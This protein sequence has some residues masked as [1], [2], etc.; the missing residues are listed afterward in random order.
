MTFFVINDIIYTIVKM[1]HCF[2]WRKDIT[3][4]QLQKA[5]QEIDLVDK[6]MARL[7]ERRMKAVAEVADHKKRNGLPIFDPDREEAVVRKNAE[8]LED[9]DLRPY[10][11]EFLRDTMKAS[12]HY[13]KKRMEGMQVAFCGIEGAFASIAAGK[14]FP[15]A[16]QVPFA[17]FHTAYEAVEK[18][19]CDVAVLPM[20]NSTAGEVSQVLD[21]MYAGSL[22]VTGV[23][24]LSVRHCLLGTPD[25]ELSDVKKVVSH[26]QALMQCATYIEEHKLEEIQAPNT[27]MAA[28]RVAEKG[29]PAVAA[30][31]NA[32]NAELYGL[33]V[34]AHDINEVGLNTTRFAVLSRSSAPQKVMGKHSILMFTVRN[35]AGFLAKAI[36]V[37]GDYGYNMRCLRSRPMKELLWQYYFYVELEG[38]LDTENGKNM[39]KALELYCERLRVVGSF[40]YPADLDH[41][42][43][44]L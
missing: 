28:K 32:E 3:M 12:R 40:R 6:E 11:V 18:G 34:L 13:Q 17:D 30:I 35:E 36:N 26:P 23:Y 19:D 44:E 29:D 39:I 41:T 1:P 4:D 20:E 15:G 22:V 25:A 16:K 5:R 38:D 21:L 8:R 27:A 31:A 43:V 33:K 9:T 14:I 10:Y 24:S 7:F 37:I 2:L 42:E